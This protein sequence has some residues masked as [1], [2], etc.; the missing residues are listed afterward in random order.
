MKKK[1]AVIGVL[2]VMAVI[3]RAFQLDLVN[4]REA[5]LKQSYIGYVLP[6]KITKPASLEFSG[7]VSDFLFLKISTFFGGKFINQERMNSRHAEFLY[8]SVDILT[9]LDPW[10]WD[11]YLMADMILAWDFKRVDLANKLLHKAAKYR[12]ADFKVPYYLGFNYFYFLKDNA[13]GAR[14]MM[15]AARLPG[16]PSY[17]SALATR[18]AMYQNQHGPAIVF[19]NDILKTTQ[20]PDLARQ[21]ARRRNALIILDKLEKQV[22]AYKAAFGKWPEKLSDLVDR[23]L[24]DAIPDDPYG[25]TFF[26]MKNKRVF[27]TSKLIDK[28]P[29]TSPAPEE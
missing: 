13:N 9:D 3:C 23:G 19:L 11:A 1:A 12:T 25:G 6:S 24:I 7:I 2:V 15:Q 26:L 8:E 28:K 4:R 21:L 20:N 5:L 17:L 16:A 14:Y 18:L 10:F 27:T 29:K 22:D